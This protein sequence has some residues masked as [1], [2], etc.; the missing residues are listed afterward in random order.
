MAVM[1]KRANCCS[2]FVLDCLLVV[3]ISCQPTHVLIRRTIFGTTN[4]SHSATNPS[5][6]PWHICWLLCK[7]MGRCGK[8]CNECNYSFRARP[9][10]TF[11]INI[12]HR[13]ARCLPCQDPTSRWSYPSIAWPEGKLIE[14]LPPRWKVCAQL[15]QVFGCQECMEGNTSK[16]GCIM[17]ILDIHP[18]PASKWEV[19]AH[20]CKVFGCQ[21]CMEILDPSY[22]TTLSCPLSSIG[23]LVPRLCLSLLICIFCC[24]RAKHRSKHF[25]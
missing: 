15:C 12:V 3:L 21:E 5:Q 1:Q 8:K 16:Q 25:P 24:L 18:A 22:S 6:N 17:Y 7:E 10:H 13:D 23:P 11:N 14:C 20:L 4:C 2:M 9:R 19:C